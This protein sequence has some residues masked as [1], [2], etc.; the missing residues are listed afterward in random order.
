MKNIGAS[1]FSRNRQSL[2]KVATSSRRCFSSIKCVESI[3]IVQF[4][5]MDLPI[6]G[7]RLFYVLPNKM[8]VL[9]QSTNKGEYPGLS[10]YLYLLTKN[11]SKLES[12]TKRLEKMKLYSKVRS[13]DFY[14]H[15]FVLKDLN[16]LVP[17]FI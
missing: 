13:Y 11:E 12:R 16:L 15:L 1:Y 17:S 7:K 14:T 5:N 8:F 6:F 3:P 9:H 10:L 4:L 2:R